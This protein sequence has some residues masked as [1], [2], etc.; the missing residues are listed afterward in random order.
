MRKT[1]G[2]AGYILLTGGIAHEINNP[3]R[4]I[5]GRVK[6]KRRLRI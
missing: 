6:A 2:G 3:L 4:G 1:K 5:A